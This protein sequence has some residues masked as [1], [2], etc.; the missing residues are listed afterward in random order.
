M[1]AEAAL[2]RLLSCAARH[3]LLTYSRAAVGCQ[4]WI[5]VLRGE[6]GVY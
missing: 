5:V 6:G 3:W 2:E 1:S 4:S